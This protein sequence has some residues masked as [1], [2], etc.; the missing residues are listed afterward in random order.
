MHSRDGERYDKKE[1]Q[2]EEEKSTCAVSG[3]EKGNLQE[4]G[5]SPYIF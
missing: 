4:I 1:K 2:K 5:D 3:T